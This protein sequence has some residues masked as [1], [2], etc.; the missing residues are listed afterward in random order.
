M[1]PPV[2]RPH[3]AVGVGSASHRGLKRRCAMCKTPP[4]QAKP[5]TLSHSAVHR[6]HP[7]ATPVA[8]VQQSAQSSRAGVVLAP[9]LSG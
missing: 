1:R 4:V 5:C 8:E 2:S 7:I 6:A 3:T 9:L